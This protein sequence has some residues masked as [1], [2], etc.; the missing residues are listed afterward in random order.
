MSFG[1]I[2]LLLATDMAFHCS[3]IL[4][5]CL[6]GRR[7]MDRQGKTGPRVLFRFTPTVRSGRTTRLTTWRRGV[8][9][10]STLCGHT[11]TRSPGSCVC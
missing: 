3:L 8:W 11:F 10:N 4:I 6:Q 9:I 1:Y 7:I 5:I 2:V